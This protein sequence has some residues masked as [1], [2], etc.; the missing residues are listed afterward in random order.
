MDGV[1]HKKM[2]V[3]DTMKILATIESN[4]NKLLKI[5]YFCNLNLEKTN[6]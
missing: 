6:S 1:F 5:K 4:S 3:R 2:C